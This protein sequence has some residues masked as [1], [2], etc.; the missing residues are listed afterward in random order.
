MGKIHKLPKLHR[1]FNLNAFVMLETSYFKAP[2][3]PELR[4]DLSSAS[5]KKKKKCLGMQPPNE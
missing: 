3:I 1:P 5:E 4:F 2:V